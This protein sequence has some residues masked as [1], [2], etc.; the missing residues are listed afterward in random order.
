[1]GLDM[2]LYERTYCPNVW[3]NDKKSL[4]TDI[5]ANLYDYP[6]KKTR[7]KFKNVA[8]IYCR[9]GYWRKANA[10]HQF[11]LDRCRG[12]LDI[13]DCNGRDLYVS[14]VCLEEL[15]D[16]CED[17]LELKGKAF[18]ERAAQL[19][20]TSA[21]FF[22]GSYEYDK[23]YRQDVKYTLKLIKSLD[24]AHCQYIYNADW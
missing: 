16:I 5:T 18:R 13:E 23:W 6:E 12:D 21:G 3:R 20:P 15:R 22:W 7:K 1:M 17:L 19:L 14:D 24:L 4:R 11:I 2:Y 8:Y 9:K 10:I